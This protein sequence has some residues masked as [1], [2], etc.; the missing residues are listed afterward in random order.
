MLR[1]IIALIVAT[2]IIGGGVVFVRSTF[3]ELNNQ[4]RQQLRAQKAAGTLPVRLQNTDVDRVTVGDDFA[5]QVSTDMQI[6]L[7]IAQW[8]DGFWPFLVLIIMV[9]CVGAAWG[10]GRVFAKGGP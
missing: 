10:I 1:Y 9:L 8:L 3:G 2:L 7:D 5:M 6:R 4:L